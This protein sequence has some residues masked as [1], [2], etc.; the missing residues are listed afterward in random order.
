MRRTTGLL[1]V[2]ILLAP[3]GRS[4]AGT[5]VDPEPRVGFARGPNLEFGVSVLRDAAGKPSAKRLTYSSDGKSNSTVLRVEGTDHVLGGDKGKWVEKPAKAANGSRAV[6]A[7]DGVRVR[8]ILEIVPSKQ[9][10]EVAKGVRRRLL[11]TCL[12]RYELENV[13]GQ[14]RR[15]GLRL[16]LDTLIGSNDGVPFAV[17]GLPGVVNKSRDFKAPAEVPDFVQALEANN[18]QNPGTVAH[19]TLK[20]GGPVEAPG[21]ALLTR[22]PG[23]SEYGWL[24][25]VRDMGDDSCA[26]LYWDEKPL[27]PGARRAVGFAYGLGAVSSSE[28]GELRLTVD[29]QFQVGKTFSVLAYVNRPRPGQSLTLKL[30]P[31]L[32][33]L[34]GKDVEPVPAAK[35]GTDTSTVTWRVQAT[36]P[37]RFT[38][39]VAASNGPEQSQTVVIEP[40]P[41]V[42]EEDKHKDGVVEVPTL[43]GLP[44]ADAKTKVAEKGLLIKFE[45]S[46][47]K[48]P[49]RE[50]QFTVTSQ[51]PAAGSKVKKG[52]VVTAQVYPAFTPGTTFVLAVTGPR[53]VGKELTL[54][55]TVTN[56][57]PKQTLTLEAPP[58]LAAAEASLTQPV[59]A[60]GEQEVGKVEWK[61]K[62][63]RA[64]EHPLRV[65]SSGGGE[66]SQTVAIAEAQPPAKP[67]TDFT[68]LDARRALKMSVNLLETD[69]AYDVDGDGR[70]TSQDAMLIFRRALAAPK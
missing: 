63:A 43:T 40:G 55:A 34:E 13:G 58:G 19:L 3:P 31:G 54:T 14:A 33:R 20:L 65:T 7:V 66:Q 16:Q 41:V 42:V 47:E 24:V 70:V 10:V 22:W 53:E 45:G 37:G 15:V 57:E 11:D 50:K 21:R 1:L 35:A 67:R 61:L 30:P 32:E 44:A 36:K 4:P 8:H 48:P 17:P 27:A 51:D 60:A 62:A 46:P 38:I 39:A 26:V 56:P 18:L 9:P 12:V 6:W 28:Q 59:P 2:L 68:A 23:W 69:P 25:P 64:G 52:S 5:D 29:G 49:T